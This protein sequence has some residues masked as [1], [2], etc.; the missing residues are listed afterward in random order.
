[1]D[2]SYNNLL[3]KKVDAKF[4]SFY[5]FKDVSRT[6]TNSNYQF[7]FG[8]NPSEKELIEQA[9]FFAQ[10][11]TSRNIFSDKFDYVARSVSGRQKLLSQAYQYSF[12]KAYFYSVSLQSRNFVQIPGQSFVFT[13]HAHLFNAI[14]NGFSSI[15][16]LGSD[17]SSVNID[18]AMDSDEAL[19]AI[20]DFSIFKLCSKFNS[21][22]K[23]VSLIRPELEGILSF[24]SE[25]PFSDYV[26]LSTISQVSHLDF[27]PHECALGNGYFDSSLSF[28]NYI[29]S[30]VT[31]SDVCS[32][33]WS[34]AN[35][36]TGENIP[37]IDVD[38]AV[39]DT[40]STEKVDPLTLQFIVESI[41]GFR[42]FG[43][44][45]DRGSRHGVNGGLG[46]GQG[47]SDLNDPNGSDD[48]Y[49]RPRNGSQRD[50]N[51]NNRNTNYDKKG[52]GRS[53]RKNG[54]NSSSSRFSLT[55]GARKTITNFLTSGNV[56]NKTNINL[57]ASLLTEVI[58]R[59]VDNKQLSA[60]IGKSVRQ[61]LEEYNVSADNTII[62]D[63]RKYNSY[64][65][66]YSGGHKLIVGV[67]PTIG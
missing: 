57:V 34:Y 50:N 25:Y 31:S 41:T 43:Q 14:S 62:N 22:G 59:K 28:Y 9:D 30:D 49:N 13:G 56:I 54:N 35:F 11:L 36:I 24:L 17:R 63:N 26:S 32:T 27:D 51:N 21:Q 48:Y 45:D 33:F 38:D 37:Y 55:K 46:S 4:S 7:S 47:P 61:V 10:F 42:A 29:E 20:R 39:Y 23:L 52:R 65:V 16:N 66:N 58:G 15:P 60:K 2:V 18:I 5:I 64:D 40:I 3:F 67:G 6:R 12:I 53:G 44:Y 8:V 1:M 19:D